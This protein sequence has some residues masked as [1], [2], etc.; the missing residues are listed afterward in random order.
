[1][2]VFIDSDVIIDLL[3]KRQEFHKQAEVL[4]DLSA[5][6]EID[7]YTTPVAISNAF[8]IINDVNKRKDSKT[9]IINLRKLIGILS[10][11]AYEIDNAATSRIKDF[12]DA[13]Q[14]HCCIR[15]GIDYIVTRNIGDYKSS[16]IPVSD[17]KEFLVIYQAGDKI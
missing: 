17:P 6:K 2:K 7:L 12:E 13:L 15:N 11:D 5:K 10:M 4:F 14:Y 16:D 3:L 1:M 8:Y 9:L